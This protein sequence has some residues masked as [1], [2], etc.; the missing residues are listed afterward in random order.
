MRRRSAILFG[1]LP[2]LTGD[3]IARRSLGVTFVKHFGGQQLQRTTIN[4]GFRTHKS[5]H[6]MIG[7]AGIRGSRMEHDLPGHGPCMRIPVGGRSQ[8]GDLLQII[9][10]FEMRKHSTG[11]AQEVGKDVVDVAGTLKNVGDHNVQVSRETLFNAE[12]PEAGECLL[13]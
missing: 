1:E 2:L 13:L 9:H 10:A 3:Q 11:V 12:P 5:F 7:F 8:I 4:T 6:S